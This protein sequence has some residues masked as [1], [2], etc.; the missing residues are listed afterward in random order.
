MPTTILTSSGTRCLGRVKPKARPRTLHLG[1]YLDPM[2]AAALP[3]SCDYATA[4]LASIK[5][6]FL[7]DQQGDCVIADL[8]HAIGVWTANESGSPLIPTD[9][10]IQ[11]MYNKLK[12]GPGDSGC[13]ITDV[14]DA[15]TANG[16][17]VGGQV[18][19]IDGY[20]AVD[21]RQKPLIQAAILVFGGVRLGIDLPEAWANTTDGQT[22]AATNTR[23]V[24]GHDVRGISYD[25]NGVWIAT[26]AGKRL[27]PWDVLTTSRYFDEAYTEMSPDWYAKAGS[28]P[29]GFDAATLKADL[30]LVGAG[31]LPPIVAEPAPWDWSGFA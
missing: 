16:V 4:A 14:L 22:W 27:I 15:W 11:A 23:V 20:V 19:K 24:G 17:T 10:E 13:V 3:D 5:Q 29:A 30:A 31:T 8:G 1:N 2:L 26:W 6:F 12:A 9:A 28:S 18:H 7:N 21:W 25:T